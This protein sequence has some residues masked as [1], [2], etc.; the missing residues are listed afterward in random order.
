MPDPMDKS[1][2]D[3]ERILTEFG[4]KPRGNTMDETTRQFREVVDNALPDNAFPDPRIPDTVSGIRDADSASVPGQ[5]G[6][7]QES[8]GGG[9]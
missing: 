9:R 1:A 2:S 4:K 7:P 6:N 8:G 5:D 3:R